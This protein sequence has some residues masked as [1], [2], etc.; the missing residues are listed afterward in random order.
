MRTGIGSFL[1]VCLSVG[2]ATAQPAP[3]SAPASAS[4]SPKALGVDSPIDDVL[5]ALDVRGKDMSD[6]TADVTLTDTDT[7]M[8]TD[9]TLVGKI[10]MQRLP[11]G[12]ARLRVTFDTKIVNDKKKADK[13]EYLLSK[14]WLYD[15]NY[16]DHREVRR[17][18][19]K[20]G[21]KMDLLKLGEGPFP[22]PLGQDKADV[23]RLFE[24]AKIPPGKDDPAGT[25]HV[26]LTPKPDTQFATRFKTIDFWVDPSSRFPI[27]IQTIDPNE[28]TTRTT[29]L[30][31]IKVNTNLADKDFELTPISEKEWTIREQPFED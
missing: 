19:L 28:T 5:D 30:K 9:S 25:I 11:G 6:F 7:A 31:E 13:T 16:V 18:V 2:C 24:V 21:Q 26:Q 8:G 4:S 12:D 29:E 22:L 27:K 23:H 10:A 15:R 3:T 14:G 20:P 1:I 17:Q